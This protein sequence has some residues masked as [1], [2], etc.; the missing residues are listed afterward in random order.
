MAEA[1]ETTLST[2]E[3]IA[4]GDTTQ[5]VEPQATEQTTTETQASPEDMLYSKSKEEDTS[6]AEDKQEKDLDTTS[7][8]ESDSESEAKPDVEAKKEEEASVE[9]TEYK[10]ELKEGSLIGEDD[11]KALE[12]F[13]KEKG[14]DEDSAKA[15][16]E[17][18]DSA[19]R[20]F[21]EGQESKYVAEV[22][23]WAESV[24]NDPIYGG[25]NLKQTTEKARKVLDKFGTP[26][27]NEALVKSGYGNHPEVVKLLAK[28][29]GVMSE[30]S[31]VLSREKG[32]NKSATELFYGKE[33]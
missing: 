13:A 4:T 9:T 26:E 31:L 17:G 30:D 5:V 19:V 32:Q 16:L 22:N 3:S 21:V 18:R 2:T 11:L 28:I 29:G 23:G 1:S 14:L 25:E 15:L 10:L 6:K 20:K 7:S 12:A 27:L 33:N 8:K 24:K